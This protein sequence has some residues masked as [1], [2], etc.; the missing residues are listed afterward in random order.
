VLEPDFFITMRD[1]IIKTMKQ[2]KRITAIINPAKKYFTIVIVRLDRTIQNLMKTLDSP[3]EPED[4]RTLLYTQ[5]LI[6]Y[7]VT[8]VIL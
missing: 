7:S 1:D 8:G 3:V 6:R 5:T 4:D 2:M